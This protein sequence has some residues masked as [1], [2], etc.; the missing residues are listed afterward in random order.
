MIVFDASTLILLT[1]SELVD[2][3]LRNTAQAVMIPAEVEREC[4]KVKR[5]FD[6]LRI[7]RFIEEERIRVVR[8]QDRRLL[9][10]L[11]ADFPMGKG[12]AEAVALMMEI[13]A[14]L[15]AVDDRQGIN[16]CKLLR[17][18]FTTAIN[19]LLAMRERGWICFED[20]EQK[21][22]ALEKIGRY[23]REIVEDARRRL[24]ETK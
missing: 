13:H 23:R 10:R 5:S 11:T 14:D 18:P 16:A 19:L 24:E 9:R 15:L 21:L 20:A 4:C 22:A 1:R 8:V 2:S 3:F 6:A 17:L 7:G 12:E